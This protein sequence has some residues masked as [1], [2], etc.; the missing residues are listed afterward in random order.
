MFEMFINEHLSKHKEKK[1]ILNERQEQIIETL[2]KEK[3]ISVK[4]LSEMFFVCEMTIRRDLKELEESGYIKRYSGGAMINSEEDLMPIEFRRLL[5]SKEKKQI[6]ALTKKYLSDNIA[7]FI[8]SSST[9]HCIIPLLAEYKNITIVTNSVQ[10]LL[11]ASK[12]HIKC[13]IA[14]G[15]YYERDR[16][17]VGAKTTDFLSYINVDV[18]FFSSLGI[19]DDGV[20]SDIDEEQ[21]AVRRVVM[22]NSAKKIFMF[23]NT[24]QHKTYMYKL[25]RADDA[26]DIIII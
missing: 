15:N 17:C 26:D 12:Y 21:M 24:K 3:R 13:I 25:C 10:C 23:D 6:A 19:S 8:D 18:A 22:K 2:K 1:M 4:K 11:I 9:S 16:C 5:H 7:V 14:G 20:I